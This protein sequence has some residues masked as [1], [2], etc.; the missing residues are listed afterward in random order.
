MKDLATFVRRPF[1]A[2]CR[3]DI[4]MAD[5]LSMIEDHD[6]L[7]NFAWSWSKIII[8]LMIWSWSNLLKFFFKD[9]RSFY[10]SCSGNSAAVSQFCYNDLLTLFYNCIICQKCFIRKFKKWPSKNDIWSDLDLRSFFN[11]T[12]NHFSPYPRARVCVKN[13]Q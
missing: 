3:A 4:A 5:L 2:L 11:K 1:L 12:E 8:F 10:F 6:L 9:D 7:S 13:L